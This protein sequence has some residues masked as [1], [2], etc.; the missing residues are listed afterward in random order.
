MQIDSSTISKDHK[1]DS[2]LF[3]K[4]WATLNKKLS[5]KNVRIQIVIVEFNVWIVTVIYRT[6]PCCARGRFQFQYILRIFVEYI[7]SYP[8]IFARSQ[9]INTRVWLAHFLSLVVFWLVLK[10]CAVFRL[11]FKTRDK[12]SLTIWLVN[13]STMMTF[14]WWKYQFNDLIGWD[15]LGACL[16]VFVIYI[17]RVMYVLVWVLVQHQLWLHT[18]IYT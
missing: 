11:V 4:I 18:Y 6:K 2:N 17:Y 7:L 12:L 3:Y 1:I 13:Y 9:L 8:V 16:S 5:F 14:D 10:F 15:G